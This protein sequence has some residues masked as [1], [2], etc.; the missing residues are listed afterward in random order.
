MDPLDTVDE[1]I[2]PVDLVEKYHAWACKSARDFW[3]R[4]DRTV[5]LDELMSAARLGLWEAATRYEHQRG[6]PFCGYAKWWL[7]KEFKDCL[8]VSRPKGYRRTIEMGRPAPLV[9]S[10]G[11]F[12]SRIDARRLNPDVT[13][14]PYC[15]PEE[16]GAPTPKSLSSIWKQI[17]PLLTKAEYS[18]LVAHYRRGL[19]YEAIAE[20]FGK[21]KQW[22]HKIVHRALEKIRNDSLLMEG[23]K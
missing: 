11:E 6:I 17:R 20:R 12:F 23:L 1:P 16:L 5:D 10:I 21:H 22:I 3:N 2:D 13:Y 14:E 9:F 15:K 19:K 7:R 8:R 4:T 18:Y